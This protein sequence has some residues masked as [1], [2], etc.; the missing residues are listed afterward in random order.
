[1]RSKIIYINQQRRRELKSGITFLSL[2]LIL[3]V[4]SV[5]AMCAYVCAG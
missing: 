3:F 5:G 1:M 4:C 2:V